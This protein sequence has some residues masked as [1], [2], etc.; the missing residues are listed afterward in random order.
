MMFVEAKPITPTNRKV[1]FG[2]NRL[3]NNK[4]SELEFKKLIIAILDFKN[5][6]IFLMSDFP[7]QD[8]RTKKSLSFLG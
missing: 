2:V 3:A 8:S 7:C 5:A 4:I 1:L 6:L